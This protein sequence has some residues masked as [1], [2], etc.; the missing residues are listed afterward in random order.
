MELRQL[1]VFVAVAEE[2]NFTRAAARLFVAQSGLSATIR[3]L[4]RELQ[5]P[6][7]RRTTRHVELTPAGHAL[8]PEA[9]RTLASA[10]AATDAVAAVEGLRHG[11]LALGTMQASS[12]IDLPG[13]LISYRDAYP[14]IELKLQQA[15]AAE[16]GRMLQ[17]HI[18]DVIF[19][20]EADETPPEILSM[21]LVQSPVIVACRA[22]HPLAAKKTI[23]LKLL[24]DHP[25]VSFPSGW[26]VR[27]LADQAMQ[28]VGLQPRYAFEVND[29][30]TV[31]DLLQAGCG[32]GVMPRVIAALRPDLRCITI[33]GPQQTWTVAAQVPSPASPNPAARALWAMLSS[34][35]DL[36]HGALQ[37]SDVSL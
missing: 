34:F 27:D 31:L 9:R 20:T 13:L 8:L 7:F 3:S 1:K 15:S 11:T 16:L 26:G 35:E 14:G 6:L 25:L 36:A 29:T 22:D 37:R 2:R 23:E 19:T 12:F 10:R 32:V 33:K 30:T 5:A 24:A 18:L 17:D 21:P 4:E 28:S